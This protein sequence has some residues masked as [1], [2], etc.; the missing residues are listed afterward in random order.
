MSIWM[1][2]VRCGW[3]QW[4]E[5]ECVMTCCVFGVVLTGIALWVRRRLLGK[6]Q[7]DPT[8]WHLPLPRD[9]EG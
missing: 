9:H 4:Y 5:R 3:F 8:A 1:G 7:E 2:G 6:K